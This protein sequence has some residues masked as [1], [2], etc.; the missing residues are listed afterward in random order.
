MKEKIPI[1]INVFKSLLR[2]NGPIRNYIV[3]TD[4][5][6]IINN[7]VATSE[8]SNCTVKKLTF[9]DCRFRS[10]R[11]EIQD[12]IIGEFELIDFGGDQFHIIRGEINKI[13]IRSQDVTHS[14]LSNLHLTVIKS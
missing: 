9:K 8:I 14:E 1:S 5:P 6:V 12:C 4:E 2:E 11:I 3:E 10:K 7:D 13:S